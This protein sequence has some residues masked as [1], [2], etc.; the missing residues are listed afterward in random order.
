[1]T[2][3]SHKQRREREIETLKAQILQTSRDIAL[4]EGWTEVS[5]RKIANAI[6]YTPPVI[7]EHF[8]N[9]E[10]ILI[11]L[12]SMGFRLLQ[13]ALEDA[14]ATTS[15]P[16][17]Q[18]VAV[19]EAF[20]DWAFIHPELYQVMFNLDGI[21]STPPSNLSLRNA[22]QS[23]IEIL[24]QIHLFANDTEESFFTW[25][26]TVHG[27]VSLVMS[28]QLPGLTSLMKHHMVT[29]VSRLAQRLV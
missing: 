24:R 15:D 23:V 28:G 22:A 27:Y 20:W 5:I 1:M 29:A 19:S 14:R 18:L 8:K 16:V 7:Y 21:K 13:Q 6:E 25:W 26:A 10:A 4:K 2:Q 17:R 3:I 9:K 12:E 11:E